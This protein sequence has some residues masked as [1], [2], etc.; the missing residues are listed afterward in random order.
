L[1][2]G[3]ARGFRTRQL[4]DKRY[5]EE[6]MQV[7]V[8]EMKVEIARLNEQADAG[9]RE[10]SA[11]KHYEKRVKELAQEL[12]GNNVLIASINNTTR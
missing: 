12:T 1:R 4:Q 8:R 3:T 5:W 10:K 7:K 11:K 9:E 6:M 2:T